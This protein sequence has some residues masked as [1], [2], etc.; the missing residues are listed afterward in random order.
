MKEILYLNEAEVKE[1]LKDMDV[2]KAS[3]SWEE[4]DKIYDKYSTR[5]AEPLIKFFGE[6][7]VVDLEHDIF[8]SEYNSN[9]Y[10]F[11]DPEDGIRRS[12]NDWP[13]HLVLGGLAHW[14]YLKMEELEDK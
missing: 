1:I 8:N 9:I 7:Y 4:V 2:V 6:D 12:L 10:G 13:K 14:I 5:F 11:K 3:D